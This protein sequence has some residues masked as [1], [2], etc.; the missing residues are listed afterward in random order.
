MSD[1]EKKI[2][3][4]LG[5]RQGSKLTP[6]NATHD[7]IAKRLSCD[8]NNLPRAV[9][10]KY[11]GK[12]DIQNPSHLQCLIQWP[13]SQGDYQLISA[14]VPR[15]LKKAPDSEVWTPAKPPIE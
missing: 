11:G 3:I 9:T 8:I 2:L 6:E 14:T 10:P 15:R 13:S 12:R 5:R 1:I 7:T 4:T